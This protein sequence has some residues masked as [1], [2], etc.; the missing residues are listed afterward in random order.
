MRIMI[1]LSNDALAHLTYGHCRW[2]VAVERSRITAYRMMLMGDD[3]IYAD[4]GRIPA[5]VPMRG[6]P[7]P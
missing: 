3:D 5:L 6:I 2:W 1:S 4:I 7:W